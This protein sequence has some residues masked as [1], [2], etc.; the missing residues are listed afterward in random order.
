MELKTFDLVTIYHRE[1]VAVILNYG[2]VV[3]PKE[4]KLH[5]FQAVRYIKRLKP[6][7]TEAFE[8]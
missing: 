3:D 8:N 7:L 2:T 1:I 5:N 4:L 6:F